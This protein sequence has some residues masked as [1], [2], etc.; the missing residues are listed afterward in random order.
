[1]PVA[2]PLPPAGA[3]LLTSEGRVASKRLNAI[4]NTNSA[5]RVKG[6]LV[7]VPNN[8]T[9]DKASRRIAPRNTGLLLGAGSATLVTGAMPLTPPTAGAKQ[10]THGPAPATPSSAQAIVAPP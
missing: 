3:I 9:N 10:P 8:D 6:K 4:K 2:V 7:P 5:S 1:M